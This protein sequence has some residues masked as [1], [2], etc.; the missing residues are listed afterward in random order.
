MYVKKGALLKWIHIMQNKRKV[1]RFRQT[2]LFTQLRHSITY[3]SEYV[4]LNIINNARRET[5][6][7]YR[8]IKLKE[9]VL[10]YWFDKTAVFQTFPLKSKA[11]KL[12]TDKYCKLEMLSIWI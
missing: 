7:I 1:R 11:A 6:D 8:R 3:W 10:G 2:K 12:V 4:Q 5:A 9:F